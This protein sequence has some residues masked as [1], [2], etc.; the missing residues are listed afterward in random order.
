[1]RV[2]VGD[3][4]LWFDVDGAEYVV[5]GPRMRRRPAVLALHGGPGADSSVPKAA[6]GF[7][8]HTAQVVYLDQRG[9][10][11]SDRGDPATWTLDTW[12]DDVVA[13]CQAVG[14]ERPIVLG[15][16]FGGFVAMRYAARHL[17]HPAALCLAATTA[18]VDHAASVEA[19]RRLGGDA[20]AELVRRDLEHPTSETFEQWL[21][22]AWPLTSRRPGAVEAAR[23]L[24]ARAIQHQDVNLH[25]AHG[26]FRTLDL[27]PDLARIRCPVLVLG[28]Q[29]DPLSPPA[30][31][32]ELAAHLDPALV[33]LHVLPDAG[34][35]LHRDQPELVERLLTGFVNEVWTSEQGEV[36]RAA[37]R[38]GR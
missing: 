5:D 15:G 21:R 9:N 18:R 1:M 24:A 35:M 13:F 7:L 16:S 30:Q 32:E 2:K 4:R 31:V 27:R 37:G 20:V 8:A 3:V 26:E 6:Y 12:A 11:R 22:D 19:F 38:P 33:R 10:G 28:G 34:H 36:G 23:A 14:L 17:D 25:F 29:D